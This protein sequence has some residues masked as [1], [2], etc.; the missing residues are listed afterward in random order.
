MDASEGAPDAI[1]QSA[2]NRLVVEPMF[3]ATI[4][5]IL[6]FWVGKFSSQKVTA[7][8]VRSM[9]VVASVIMALG[10]VQT[11]YSLEFTDYLKSRF[12]N[13]N[14]GDW[15]SELYR[16]PR[17]IAAPKKSKN[18]II[19]YV[20]SLE[21]NRIPKDSNIRI[22]LNLG[23]PKSFSIMPGTQWTLAGFVSSQ[24][25]VPLFPV[26]GVGAN[27]YDL[28]ETSFMKN[29]TCLG[30]ILSSHG[31]KGEYIG[32][33]RSVFAGKDNFLKS[34]GFDKVTGRDEL[35]AI[36]PLATFPD[37]W[38]GY[39]DDLLFDFAKKR[40]TE[41]NNSEEPFFFSLLTLDTHGPKGIHTEFCK[42]NNFPE[43]IDGIFNC[44]VFQVD[45]FIRWLKESGLLEN[46]VVVVMGDHPFMAPEYRESLI[47]K[48]WKSLSSRDVFFGMS[49]PD[50]QNVDFPN[51]NHF[52]VAPT[53]L[54][55]L[56]FQ[57]EGDR[58]GLGRNLLLVDPNQIEAN[59]EFLRSYIR[60]PSNEYNKLWG[61]E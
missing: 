35:S 5:I 40:L 6:L 3:F 54:G 43:T 34:H 57:L 48:K 32:G 36:Y 41:L 12:D 20:E 50:K 4:F 60:R 52:D 31:Y 18:L 49:I 10:L 58:F 25:A 53:I 7:W 51:M 2:M 9:V 37:G 55:A 38:W 8:V 56:G 1:V 27:R 61:F 28:L 17:V 47:D 24:C 42:R 14:R 23:Q 39:G 26:S 19:L 46:S 22:N 59:S 30:D 15:M 16:T 13:R 44:S 29:A 33:A 11:S 21:S 45:E